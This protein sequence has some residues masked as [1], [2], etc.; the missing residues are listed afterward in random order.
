MGPDGPKYGPKYMG[1]LWPKMGPIWDLQ[2]SSWPIIGNALPLKGLLGLVARRPSSRGHLAGAPEE[3]LRRLSAPP[4]LLPRPL[5]GNPQEGRGAPSP[6]AS[7]QSDEI[8]SLRAPA[9]TNFTR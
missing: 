9:A 8:K 5:F 4:L 6:A 2:G 3:T 7:K 1:P